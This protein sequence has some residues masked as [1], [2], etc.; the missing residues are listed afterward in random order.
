M[1]KPIELGL[2]LEGEDAKRFYEYMKNPTY[3]EKTKERL[4]KAAKRAGI[5]TD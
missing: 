4:K 5:P 1:A 3:P 2:T